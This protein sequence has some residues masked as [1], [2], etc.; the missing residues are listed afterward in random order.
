MSSSYTDIYMGTKF[1]G[2]SSSSWCLYLNTCFL[3]YLNLTAVKISVTV[4]T[5]AMIVFKELT[6]SHCQRRHLVILSCPHCL[7][8]LAPGHEQLFQCWSTSRARAKEA[9]CLER[10][11]QPNNPD[12]EFQS[13]AYFLNSDGP[14]CYKIQLLLENYSSIKF[15]QKTN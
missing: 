11:H 1:N 10:S 6:T 12:S 3:W 13:K 14:K 7:R 4:K 5:K 8:V 15:N 2:N 9:G